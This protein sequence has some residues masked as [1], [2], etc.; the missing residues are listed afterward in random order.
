MKI[1]GN[2]FSYLTIKIYFQQV[3]KI[4]QQYL[5]KIINHIYIQR[6]ILYDTL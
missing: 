6:F 5:F 2:I 4:F 1:N 3:N